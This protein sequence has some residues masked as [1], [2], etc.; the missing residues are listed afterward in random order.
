MDDLRLP[1]HVIDRP[2]HR[3][4]A[5]LQRDAKAWSAPRGAGR[6]A[7]AM[8]NPTVRGT[9]P[10]SSDVLGVLRLRSRRPMRPAESMTPRPGTRPGRNE[11]RVRPGAR[12]TNR[13]TRCIHGIGHGLSHAN[14]RCVYQCTNEWRKG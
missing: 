6:S 5:R 4:A 13:T 3:W 14:S 11:T 2:E 7:C 1:R 8:G 12:S 9:S 10:S